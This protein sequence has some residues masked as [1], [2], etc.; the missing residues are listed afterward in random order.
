MET[1]ERG[2]QSPAP[3]ETNC[4]WVDATTWECHGKCKKPTNWKICK[5]QLSLIPAG[6]VPAKWGDDCLQ[7][8]RARVKEARLGI[9]Q[10]DLLDKQ[11]SNDANDEGC[12]IL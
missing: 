5:D 11:R 9:A 8:A 6:D 2:V 1:L 3:N 7:L 4:V 12:V 10:F